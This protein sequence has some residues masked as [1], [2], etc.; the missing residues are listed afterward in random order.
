MYIHDLNIVDLELLTILLK[1][2]QFCCSRYRI[3]KPLKR[4]PVSSRKV[5]N[6]GRGN[7]LIV[8]IKRHV[9]KWERNIDVLR[10]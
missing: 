8:R 9:W 5:G 3:L 1:I 6:K 2:L 7:D 10:L 4:L